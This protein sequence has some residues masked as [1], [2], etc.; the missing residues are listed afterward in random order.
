MSHFQ[1]QI[2]RST[3]NQILVIILAILLGMKVLAVFY[4]NWKLKVRDALKQKGEELD[5]L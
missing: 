4:Q 1:Y 5:L 2:F 3:I